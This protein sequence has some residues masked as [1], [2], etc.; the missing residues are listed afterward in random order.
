MNYDLSD[1]AGEFV[2]AVCVNGAV[3]TAML[4]SNRMR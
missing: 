3:R 4:F 2:A 1:W